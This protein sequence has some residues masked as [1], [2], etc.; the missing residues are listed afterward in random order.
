MATPDLLENIESPFGKTFLELQER[1][2]TEVP[3]VV[4]IEQDLGQLG[5]EDPRKSM[6]FPGVLIDFPNTPFS[7]LQGKNQLGQPVISITLVF[8]NYNQ[9]WQDAPLDVRKAGLKYLEIEQKLF[10]AVQTWEGDFCQSLNRTA[11]TG[12]NRNDV[13]L[14]VRELT[15][16][17]EF[18]DYSCDDDSQTVTISLST[19]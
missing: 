14:R 2:K 1:I 16:T 18:E 13:G 19:E 6:F 12:H 11:A 5:T 8:D 4:Y 15:F 7:N 9:T 17:G 10:M 3:E